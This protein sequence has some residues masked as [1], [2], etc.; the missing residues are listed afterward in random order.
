MQELYDKKLVCPICDNKYTSKRVKYSKMRVD[1]RDSD[2]FTHYKGENPV[3]YSVSSCNKCGFTCLDSEI[4]NIKPDKKKVI[5]ENITKNWTDKDF[6]GYR[7]N[8]EAEVATKLAIYCGQLIDL[9][10]IYLA[11][12]ALRLAWIYRLD[13]KPEEEERFLK[14]SLE[15]F[16]EGYTNERIKNTSFDKITIEYLIGELNRRLGNKK[17]AIQWFNTVVSNKYTSNPRI[18]KLAR[19]QW[20][21]AKEK[22]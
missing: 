19:E 1:G 8:K 20:R 13:N 2:L 6:C 4:N 3:K 17:Q 16:K 14:H 9:P 18:E 12:L 21:L 22:I 5:L 7:T 11:S 10:N 15:F